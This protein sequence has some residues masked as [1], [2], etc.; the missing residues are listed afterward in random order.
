MEE[1][2]N[3]SNID[4]NQL[5]KNGSSAVDVFA[6]P[7][8]QF[9]INDNGISSIKTTLIEDTSIQSEPTQLFNNVKCE[10][11]ILQWKCE[12][13]HSS[14]STCKHMNRKKCQ[15]DS[16]KLVQ[17]FN[18]EHIHTKEA[19]LH[20]EQQQQNLGSGCESLGTCGCIHFTEDA[21]E[22]VD[23]KQPAIFPESNDI[24]IYPYQSNKTQ[25]YLRR[26]YCVPKK[27]ANDKTC[28]GQL[29]L[30]EKPGDHGDGK[31]SSN[32]EVTNHG[33]YK[34]THISNWNSSDSQF[35]GKFLLQSISTIPNTHF[36]SLQI[37]Y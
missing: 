19:Q 11:D 10:N 14:A 27:Q 3:Y 12:N 17:C 34:D 22:I 33:Y 32:S 30:V 36:W 20:C 8:P 23:R 21:K 6:H 1:N 7:L 5:F 18:L 24:V 4:K 2:K 25:K 9:S 15:S 28:N 35:K 13:D 26:K 16:S 31:K 29:K 37:A